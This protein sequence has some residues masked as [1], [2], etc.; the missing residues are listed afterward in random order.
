VAAATVPLLLWIA[1]LYLSVWGIC[2]PDQACPE[3][4]KTPGWLWKVA[5]PE[6]W[7]AA[8]DFIKSITPEW[9]AEAI[10]WM[11]NLIS[12]AAQFSMAPD[13]LSR[14]QL[15]FRWRALTQP[16]AEIAPVHG[17]NIAKLDACLTRFAAPD[18]RSFGPHL[19]LAFR[20]REFNGNQGPLGQNFGCPN[21]HA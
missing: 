9:I 19:L 13:C 5:S 18:D 21:A 11:A 1:Y 2:T 12:W 3:W 17:W 15:S 6:S 10:G 16:F 20:Q 4:L 14:N 7:A 8:F